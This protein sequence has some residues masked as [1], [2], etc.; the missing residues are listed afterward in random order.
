MLTYC[1]YL[2]KNEYASNVTIILFI[3]F[4]SQSSITNLKKNGFSKTI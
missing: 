3:G 2:D 1:Q 4:F